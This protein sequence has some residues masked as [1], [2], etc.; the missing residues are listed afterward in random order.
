MGGTQILS[1][2]VVIGH[3]SISIRYCKGGK[4][5]SGL[6]K[7]MFTWMSQTPRMLCKL[8]TLG[9]FIEFAKHD[10]PLSDW[11]CSNS[12]RPG[13]NCANITDGATC[14]AG[15]WQIF[16]S[17]DRQRCRPNKH[18]VNPDSG[19]TRPANST[20]FECANKIIPAA[21]EMSQCRFVDLLR[22]TH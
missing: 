4:V 7:K 15:F 16:T 14:V 9:Q 19:S 12:R 6:T 5:G 8:N 21:T 17:I 20:K 18:T 10:E 1:F 22:W 3:F 11:D 2:V 13:R